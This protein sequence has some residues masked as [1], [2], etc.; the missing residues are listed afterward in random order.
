LANGN[1]AWGA[2][3]AG[4]GDV[5]HQRLQITPVGELRQ[6]KAK[7]AQKPFGDLHL[8]Q[9]TAVLPKKFSKGREKT[10]KKS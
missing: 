6:L 4:L 9:S 2:A 8:G 3:V 7:Q 1:Q 10:E 5:N